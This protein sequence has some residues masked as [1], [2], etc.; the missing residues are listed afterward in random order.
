MEEVRSLCGSKWIGYNEGLSW[1]ISIRV[2]KST[3]AGAN[4]T[5]RGKINN[6]L[7]ANILI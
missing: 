6:T 4:F 7:E 1:T 3:D 5:S 2:Y